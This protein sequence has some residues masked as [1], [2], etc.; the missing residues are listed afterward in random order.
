MGLIHGGCQGGLVEG[1]ESL[2]WENKGGR[3]SSKGI[4][5]KGESLPIWGIYA[6]GWAGHLR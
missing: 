6:R 3:T 4:K 2:K 5:A 1:M